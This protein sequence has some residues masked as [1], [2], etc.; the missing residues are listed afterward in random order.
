M[1]NWQDIR[2]H[3]YPE[4]S[5]IASLRHGPG[6]TGLQCRIFRCDVISIL[7]NIDNVTHLAFK[8]DFERAQREL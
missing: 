1:T 4:L 6:F 3:I 5:I 7:Y 8:I 2:F